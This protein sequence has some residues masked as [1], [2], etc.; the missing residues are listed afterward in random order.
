MNTYSNNESLH[1]VA[2][3][4]HPELIEML[5]TLSTGAVLRLPLSDYPVLQ[6]ASIEQ[7]RQYSLI[8][9]GVGVHWPALDED[10]SLGL[11][12]ALLP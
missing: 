7:L 5:V 4:F 3:D 6:N 2:L 11:C 8:G 9:Y 1:I 10:L 12:K